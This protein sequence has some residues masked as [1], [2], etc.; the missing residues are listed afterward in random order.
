MKYVYGPEFIK[1]KS[2]VDLTFQIHH[3]RIFVVVSSVRDLS[4]I[5]RNISEYAMS[6]F[7]L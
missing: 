7:T 2:T 3:W 1:F 4:V 5:V 6:N